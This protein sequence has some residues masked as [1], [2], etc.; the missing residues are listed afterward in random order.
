MGDNIGPPGRRSPVNAILRY[1]SAL[2]D[3]VNL[4]YLLYTKQH[5]Y[6]HI[7]VTYQADHILYN[8]LYILTYSI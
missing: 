8:S 3:K 4:K 5:I 6:M 1:K 7:R 2:K